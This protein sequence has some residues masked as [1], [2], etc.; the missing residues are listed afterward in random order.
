MIRFLMKKAP[1]TSS[2]K[3]SEP[4]VPADL[5]KA[6][7]AAPEVMAVWKELTPLARRDWIGW[8]D[9][10]KQAETRARRI[11]QVGSKIRDGKRRPCCYA[12]VPMALYQA[13]GK[14][15]RAKTAWSALSPDE[16]RDVACWV[17]SPEKPADRKLRVAEVCDILANGKKLKTL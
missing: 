1:Y 16:R 14:N 12:V 7:K 11:E 10:A 13:L 8:V 17:E 4:T 2:V 3:A 15:P 9:T 6:L 5:A